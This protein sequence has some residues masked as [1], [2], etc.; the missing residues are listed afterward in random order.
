MAQAKFVSGVWWITGMTPSQTPETFVPAGS[1]AVGSQAIDT[2]NK[3]IWEVSYNQ[4][5]ALH[6]WQLLARQNGTGSVIVDF[7]ASP[8]TQTTSAAVAEAEIAAGAS[9]SAWIGY[10]PTADHSEDEHLMAST[11]MG[12]VVGTITP[13]VGFAVHATSQAGFTGR[14]EIRYSWSNP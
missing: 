8:E 12:V 2:A 6:V 4:T 10:G 13:G 9:I 3:R 11:A 1:S 5:T 7:G 14:F